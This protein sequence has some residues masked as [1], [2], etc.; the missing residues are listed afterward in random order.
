MIEQ[1][2]INI[3]CISDIAADDQDD[4]AEPNQVNG[5]PQDSVLDPSNISQS[6]GDVNGGQVNERK[7][8]LTEKELKKQFK[9]I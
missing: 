9:V 4:I 7:P 2:L 8:V 6:Q 3:L 1:Y 5:A